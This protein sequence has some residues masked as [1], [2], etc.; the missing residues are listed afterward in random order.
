MSSRKDGEM[1]E[2]A[3]RFLVLQLKIPAKSPRDFGIEGL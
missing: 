2:L 1:F 3:T